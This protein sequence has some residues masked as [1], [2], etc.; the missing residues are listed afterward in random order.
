LCATYQ[1]ACS[2]VGGGACGHAA[3]AQ[4]LALAQG[5][6]AQAHVAADFAA[7][8]VQHGAGLLAAGSG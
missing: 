8:F 7:G 1:G 3:D 5:V 6:E 2:A 4:A